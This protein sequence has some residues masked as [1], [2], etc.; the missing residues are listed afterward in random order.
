[1]QAWIDYFRREQER[2]AAKRR[3][4]RTLLDL[5]SEEQR[6]QLEQ[7]LGFDITVNS[8]RYRIRPGNTVQRLDASGTFPLC[9]LCVRI[10][11]AGGEWVPDDDIAIAQKLLLEA[12]E[13]AFLRLAI[14]GR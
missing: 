11:P 8:H 13:E 12:D 4:R 5:L 6:D 14:R 7:G 9:T 2:S 10:D 3:A 1:M